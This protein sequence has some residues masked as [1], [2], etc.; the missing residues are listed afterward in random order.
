VYEGRPGDDEE[1]SALLAEA[2]LRG[3]GL[4]PARVAEVARLVRL[5]ASHD[6]APDDAAGRLLCDADLSVLGADPRTYH[7]YARGVRRE[8][9]AVP[10]PAFRAGRSAV[11]RRLVDVPE[12]FRTPRARELWE[13][14]ARANVAA[15]LARLAD[16]LTPLAGDGPE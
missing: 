6:P 10:E 12:V 13:S 11:L 5:T 8:Y 4:P 16:P 2:T 7:A 3:L 14:A 15:E 9:A 1:A